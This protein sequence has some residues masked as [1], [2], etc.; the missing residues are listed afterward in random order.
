MEV[1]SPS[2]IVLYLYYETKLANMDQQ[3]TTNF[4]KLWWKINSHKNMWGLSRKGVAI[5]QDFCKVSFF[6][7]F[8]GILFE[9]LILYMWSCIPT[10]N[11]T[12]ECFEIKFYGTRIKEKKITACNEITPMMFEMHSE[13]EQ[14]FYYNTLDLQKKFS[15]IIFVF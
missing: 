11:G 7:F 10:V 3:S 8:I 9:K 1:F 13:V 2:C 4:S 14:N 6:P 5:T 15:V 12:T